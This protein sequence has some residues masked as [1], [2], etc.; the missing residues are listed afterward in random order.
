LHEPLTGLQA[1]LGELKLQLT[2]LKQS[3][4]RIGVY[5]LVAISLTG[6][7]A[8]I[9]IPVAIFLAW[10]MF[11]KRTPA[12]LKEVKEVKESREMK[13]QKDYLSL[14]KELAAPVAK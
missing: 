6:L 2:D 11:S 5:L 14:E 1:D 4:N 13:L 8:S 3:I 10:A 12:K 7:F 9:G